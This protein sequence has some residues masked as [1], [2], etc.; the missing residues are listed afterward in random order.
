[1]PL[2]R[3]AVATGM[4]WFAEEPGLSPNM[5]YI[6]DF[7]YFID[8]FGAEYA[9]LRVPLKKCNSLPGRVTYY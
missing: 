5:P 8:F 2:L 6:S 3:R 7:D 4:T 1:M 9:T